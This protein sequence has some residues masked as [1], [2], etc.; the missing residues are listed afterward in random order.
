MF[1]PST[2]DRMIAGA[3]MMTP[4]DSAAL[5]QERCSAASVR[6]FRS[7]RRSRYSYAV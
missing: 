1:Q 5:R 3:A 6:V 2:I 4:H 7:K